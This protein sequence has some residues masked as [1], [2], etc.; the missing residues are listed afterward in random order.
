[1]DIFEI[2]ILILFSLIPIILGIIILAYIIS[3]SYKRRRKA[4]EEQRIMQ[5]QR[6]EV[7]AILSN[8]PNDYESAKKFIEKIHEVQVKLSGIDRKIV[9]GPDGTSFDIASYMR[10]YDAVKLKDSQ[11]VFECYYLYDSCSGCPYIMATDS[12]GNIYKKVEPLYLE[13]KQSHNLLKF[14]KIDTLLKSYSAKLCVKT[15]DTPIGYVQLLHF[16]EFG[17]IFSLYWHAAG[18]GKYVVTSR[19]QVLNQAKIWESSSYED[20]L[21]HD[22]KMWG[23]MKAMKKW[24]PMVMNENDLMEMKNRSFERLRAITD[25]DLE[26]TIEMDENYCYIEWV[27]NHTDHGMYRCKYQIS[28]SDCSIKQVAKSSIISVTPMFIY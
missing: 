6:R 24:G 10:F 26:P 1:M 3:Q 28:R 16:C 11:K 13:G 23:P 9:F 2:I 8:R 7:S 12:I 20:P 25:S 5:Q 27:E 22:L 18:G 4:D 17:D 14:S 21:I 19:E 15:E